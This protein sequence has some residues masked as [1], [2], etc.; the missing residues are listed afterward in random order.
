MMASA[1]ESGV[2]QDSNT[3]S[4]AYIYESIGRLSNWLEKNDYGGYDTFD[5]LNDRFFRP[6]TFETKLLRIV[7]QQSVRRFPVN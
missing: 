5:G 1:G 6:F 3:S 2:G 4:R 7:L